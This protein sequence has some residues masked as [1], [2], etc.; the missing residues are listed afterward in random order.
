MCYQ[1]NICVIDDSPLFLYLRAT[2]GYLALKFILKNDGMVFFQGYCQIINIF[3]A[4]KDNVSKM[5]IPS[6]SLKAFMIFYNEFLRGQSDTI[7]TSGQM[8]D[9]RNDEKLHITWESE[10]DRAWNASNPAFSVCDV[11]AYGVVIERKYEHLWTLE[12]Y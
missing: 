9:I 2:P 5:Y 8:S 6:S 12:E 11:A 1:N 10:Y 7:E 3:A 4:G